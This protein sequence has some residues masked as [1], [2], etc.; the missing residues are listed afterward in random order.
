[1]DMT[2]MFRTEKFVCRCYY[3][4]HLVLSSSEL[5]HFGIYKITTQ[6]TSENFRNLS[7]AKVL[8][9]TTFTSLKI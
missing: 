6:S 1:M 7:E 9:I 2:K 8:L 5:E 4:V 3:L